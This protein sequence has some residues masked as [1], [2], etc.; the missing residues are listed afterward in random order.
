MVDKR[1]FVSDINKLVVIATDKFRKKYSADKRMEINQTTSKKDRILASLK[2]ITRIILLISSAFLLISTIL[3]LV[4]GRQCFSIYSHTGD[5]IWPTII[6][7]I[8]SLL[9]SV[10]VIIASLIYN[11]YN[12][13]PIWSLLKKEILFLILTGILMTIFYFV[14]G[15]TI[16]NC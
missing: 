6:V 2:R 16:S 5:I 7:T 1:R 8:Y 11:A 12:R 3:L 9:Y 15:Y 4:Y 13:H 14:N 10:I